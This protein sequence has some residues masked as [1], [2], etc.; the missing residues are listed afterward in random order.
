LIRHHFGNKQQLYQAVFAGPV[1][2]Y[3]RL[4]ISLAHT[5]PEHAAE[6]VVRHFISTWRDP[7]NGPA[8]RS[9]ARGW[10]GDPAATTLLRTHVETVLIPGVAANSASPNFTSQPP[11][12]TSSGWCSPTPS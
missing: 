8:L 5:P 7:E 11:T 2:H 4:V 6:A 10:F 9:L 12:P 3:D 1:D